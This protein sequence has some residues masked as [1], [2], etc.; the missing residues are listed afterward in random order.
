MG[1]TLILKVH[2]YHN[3]DYLTLYAK[4]CIVIN[5]EKFQFCHDV[6]FA[7]LKITKNGIAPSDHTLS[8]I[9][10]FLTP[11]NITD[12]RSRFGPTDQVAWADSISPFME[13]FHDLVKPNTKFHWENN[14]NH[15][16]VQS[17]ELLIS[18]IIEGIHSFDITKKTCL[19]T[20][21]SRDG[22]GTTFYCNSTVIET[23]TKHQSAVKMAGN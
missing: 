18:K 4:N 6:L 12:A 8:A 22:I 15:I 23:M 20:D 1:L 7:G 10:D 2:F 19:Q 17:K 11:K 14:L 21:W 16:F 5:K 3:W 9:Q 13:P